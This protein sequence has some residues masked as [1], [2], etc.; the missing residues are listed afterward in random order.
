MWRKWYLPHDS[1]LICSITIGG[2]PSNILNLLISKQFGPTLD[3]N[4]RSSWQEIQWHFAK[5][6]P[7]QQATPG[8]WN[9][10]YLTRGHKFGGTPN[11]SHSLS[12]YDTWSR[13][14]SLIS[15]LN[16][17]GKATINFKN[18]HT[19]ICIFP[20]YPSFKIRGSPF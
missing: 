5:V 17:R 3:D 11:K 13:L 18:I 10:S 9:I 16:K 20:S 12:T 8:Q 6:V 7:H 14:Y 4:V 1:N 15:T 2:E 19:R